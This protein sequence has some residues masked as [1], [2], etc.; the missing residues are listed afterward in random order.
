MSLDQSQNGLKVEFRET[1]RY[2][3][4]WGIKH[5]GDSPPDP[6]AP[7]LAPC[8]LWSPDRMFLLLSPCRCSGTSLSSPQRCPVS[9][10]RCSFL[11]QTSNAFTKLRHKKNT[12]I[13]IHHRLLL[14]IYIFCALFGNWLKLCVTL[15][16]YNYI[17]SIM[18]ELL[19]ILSIWLFGF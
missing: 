18:G 1:E 5:S 9:P 8:G 10:P 7:C 4:F 11:I 14:L 3:T 12:Y 13:S 15:G 16:L 17:Y 6:P 19:D 2:P